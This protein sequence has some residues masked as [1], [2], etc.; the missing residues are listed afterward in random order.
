MSDKT[1]N[2]PST[3]AG[4]TLK[5]KRAVKKAKKS[6]ESDGTRRDGS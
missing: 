4:S 6:G 3:K 2:K 5:Q 1:P